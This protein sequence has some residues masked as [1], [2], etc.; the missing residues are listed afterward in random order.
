MGYRC[1]MEIREVGKTGLV[2][3]VQGEGS[4]ITSSGPI[5][6]R[7][8]ISGEGAKRA[9]WVEALKQMPDIRE[10]KIAAHRETP[11]LS[12]LAEKLQAEGF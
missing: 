9:S 12:A 11:S 8:S 10:E 6:D 5:V 4:K 1:G 7:L 3:K 2:H